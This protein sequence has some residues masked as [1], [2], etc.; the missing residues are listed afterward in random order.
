MLKFISIFE[1]IRLGFS[2]NLNY[3]VLENLDEL[4]FESFPKTSKLTIVTF[5]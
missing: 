2:E 1:T 3:K 4:R 5:L